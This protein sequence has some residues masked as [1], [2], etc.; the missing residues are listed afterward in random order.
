MRTPPEPAAATGNRTN[1]VRELPRD[2]VRW[3]HD[4]YTVA[5]H[6]TPARCGSSTAPGKTSRAARS[7]PAGRPGSRPTT[8]TPLPVRATISAGEAQA[9]TRDDHVHAG[10]QDAYE[11]IRALNHCHC[12]RPGRAS[13]TGLR[14]ARQPRQPRLRPATTPRPA[15]L[16]TSA[17]VCSANTTSTT[18]TATPPNRSRRRQRRWAKPPRMPTSSADCCLLHRP[19]STSRATTSPPPAPETAIR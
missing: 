12:R 14:L 13:A 3:P 8:S 1:D 15:R 2:A 6:V 11:A 18:T 9:M 5:F 4:R 19:R 17:A 10:P 7:W 16:R